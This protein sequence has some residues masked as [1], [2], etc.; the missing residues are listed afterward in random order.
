MCA[1]ATPHILQEFHSDDQLK[2][3]LLV[4]IWE[5]G[6]VFGPLLIGPLSEMYGR[7]PIYH[8]ANVTFIVFSA[9]AAESR[10]INMLIGCRLVLGLSV[11]STVLNPSI[12]GDMFKPESRGR[13]MAIMGMT[14]FIAPVL[15]PIIGAVISEAKGW[16]WTF[17]IVT[18]VTAAFEVIFAIT[19]RE[20]YRIIILQ[21]K[22]R[23]SQN[24]TSGHVGRLRDLHSENG[25]PN[26]SKIKLL[27]QSLCRPLKLPF[28]SLAV[29]LVSISCAIGLSYMYVIIT[30]LT[31]IFQQIYGFGEREVGLTYLGLGELVSSVFLFIRICRNIL[32]F[33]PL[34]VNKTP[35][36]RNHLERHFHGGVPR[37][38][39]QEE[40]CLRPRPW[41]RAPPPSN[42]LWQSPR[43][44]RR[45]RIR[46][47]GSSAVPVDRAHPLHSGNRVRLRLHLAVC[48]ELRG[49]RVRYLR[50]LGHRRRHGGKKYRCRCAATC[51]P[52]TLGSPRTWMGDD[53]AGPCGL[54]AFAATGGDSTAE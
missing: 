16:R 35:R 3:T 51:Q 10:S 4:S 29:L 30:N 33:V 41:A 7:L 8:A 52:P 12:V 15:G 24:Q 47:D 36:L 21:R 13:A 2:A 50:R 49:R 25:L 5:L 28:T 27:Y 39:P 23:R 43:P 19:Y 18:I 31:N 1:P 22:A 40:K 45:Y 11:A 44:S 42:A 26:T 17:W 46:L 54:V 38:V 34:P 48:L 6:E 20:S 53:C 9:I 32:H 37:L 14:P